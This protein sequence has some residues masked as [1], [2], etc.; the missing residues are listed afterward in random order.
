M[1]LYMKIVNLLVDSERR[2]SEI[3]EAIPEEK[4]VSI[5]ATV[6]MRPDLFVRVA[7]GVIGRAGRD[8]DLIKRYKERKESTR[9]INIIKP[10]R[11]IIREYLEELLYFREMSLED[12]CLRVPFPK[13]SVTCK[14]TLNPKFE[15]VGKGIW[16]LVKT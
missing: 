1:R 12:I 4:Q 7:R 16:G 15:R 8:E 6:N 13:K 11:K 10:K 14:L 2:V 3:Y 9:I 5:R